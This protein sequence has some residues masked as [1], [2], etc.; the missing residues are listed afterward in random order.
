ML[1][2]FPSI[3]AET[4]IRL[5]DEPTVG[6]VLQTYGEGN[7]P[8]NRKDLTDAFKKA[9]DRGVFIINTT[10]CLEVQHR[11][12]IDNGLIKTLSNFAVHMKKA[13]NTNLL[14]FF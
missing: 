12:V 13:M 6:V 1:R 4:V 14:V 2:I 3:S 8:H 9:S 7:A 5:L 11:Y 10:Q